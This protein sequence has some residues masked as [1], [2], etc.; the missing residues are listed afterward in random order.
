MGW[1]F[2][3]DQRRDSQSTRGTEKFMASRIQ[4]GGIADCHLLVNIPST[5]PVP[6]SMITAFL[7]TRIGVDTDFF[8][9]IENPQN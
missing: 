7:D 1:A 9:V 6:D 3:M 8:D 4:Q 5:P 2:W